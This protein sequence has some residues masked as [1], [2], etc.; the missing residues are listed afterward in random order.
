MVSRL[1]WLFDLRQG[2]FRR[3]ILLAI[4]YFLII[5]IN[6]EGQVVRD[7]LFLGHFKAGQLPYVDF[8]VAAMIGGIL[9]LYIRIG[10]FTSLV[11]LLAGTLSFSFLNVLAFWWMAHI[12]RHAT[13]LYPVVYIWVGMFGALAISQVWTLASYVF[14][15]REAR[16]LVGFVGSGG[17][18]GGI[19][20]GFIANVLAKTFGAESLFLAMAA[21]IGLS[22]IVVF[23]IRA[24]NRDGHHSLESGAAIDEQGPATLRE[25]FRLVRSSPQLMTIACLICLCSIV[26]ALAS[27]Q[28]RA[29]AQHFLINK[30]AMAAFFGSFYG[31]TGTLALLIQV[32]LTPRILRHFGIRA[33]LLILP[34]TF[35]A[36]TTALVA[37][38]ALW[39]ATLLKGT[40]RVFR[41]SVDT[42]ALQLLYLPV[43]SETKV[44]T[45]SFLDTVVLRAGDGFAAVLI[46]LLIGVMGLTVRQVCWISL[47]LLILWVI[48][49]RRAGR[50]YVDSLGESLRQQRLDAERFTEPEFDRS[51]RQMFLT[52]LRSN[53]P[54]KILYVLG[55]LETAR[56][57]VPYPA[58]RKLLDHDVPEIRAKAILVLRNKGDLSVIPRIEQLLRD[59]NLNVRTEA[60]LFLAQ[61]TTVDP[62]AR[63]QDLGDFEDFSIQASTVAFLA[64]SENKSNLDAATLILEN[65]I[66]DRGPAGARTRVESA[67]LIRLLPENWG[68]YLFQLLQDDDPAVQREAV[69][70]TLV[71]RRREFVPLLITLLGNPEVRNVAIEALVHFAENIQGSLQD[72]L[73]DPAVPVEVKREIPELLVIVAGRNARE[74]LTVNLLQ[75]DNVL[76]F[77]IISALNKLHELYPEIELAEQTIEA[78]LATEI[79]NHYRSY[80]VKGSI[81][82]H[83]SR[84]SFS[85]LQKSIDNEL[86]RIFRLL[87][88]LHLA[89]DLE[90]AFVG[91]QSGIKSEHDKALE[92]IEN[93]LKPDVRRLVIPLVDGEV[94][95]TEK[96]EIAN[97]M[98]GSTVDSTDDALRILMHTPDPWMK[99]C[100]AHLIGILG[101]RNFC[102]ELEEWTSDP[103]ALLREKAQRARDRLA[104][105]A[106][107]V[108]PVTGAASDLQLA[109]S[110][111]T[112]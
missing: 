108:V 104:V 61:H 30:N 42:A 86:E 99:S 96:V 57:D 38:G 63:I 20:G 9:A 27:W 4:Y 95:L 103:D 41:Y 68:S 8:A 5:S 70:T 13:W 111:R 59:P 25:S 2:D 90:S 10:R 76:R 53:E 71:H 52:E 26:T 83:L 67:R 87:K 37:T 54:S 3:G 15:G 39:A 64:R 55:L 105:S 29:I 56:W 106:S 69:R 33:S 81:E 78:V 72:H 36:G 40:D 47:G 109:P 82:N 32:L 93:V 16:R 110:G 65:M 62:L 6:T 75:M 1:E 48:A 31:Y 50:Q 88:M 46:L 14:S 17:I 58:L 91:L 94:G 60:L 80:Q 98:L 23:A 45:K 34:L 19:F 97:R 107:L 89:V 18:L 73:S 79:M 77:R 100:A 112:E 102:K 51:A 74:A 43:P 66:K 21:S 24:Q 101:L 92:L 7:S 12:S 11:H 35:A 84:E 85:V 49:A 44:Q 28:F 22:I